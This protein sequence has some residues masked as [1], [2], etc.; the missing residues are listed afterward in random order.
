[1]TSFTLLDKKKKNSASAHTVLTLQ[2]IFVYAFLI[3]LML[4]CL[5]PLWEMLVNSTRSTLQIQ[6]TMGWW[7]GDYLVKN[8]WIGFPNQ[9]VPGLLRNGDL[10]ILQALGNS[11]F[12]AFLTAA[13]TVYFSALTAYGIQVYNFKGKN[14]VF[15]FILLIMMIPT[16]VSAVGFFDLISRMG[17]ID[18]FWPLILPAIASPVSFFFI[19]QYLEAIL[20]MEMVEAARV[21][22]CSEIGIFHRMVLPII[23]PAL[24][25]QF[26]FSF[27]SSWSNLFIPSLILNSKNK[28]TVAILIS[29]QTAS[30][31]YFKQ[32][33]QMYCLISLAIIPAVIV[34]LIFSRFIISNVTEGSVKG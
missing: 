5:F 17:G 6:T 11:T 19:K 27:V 25:I 34:Y 28:W 9:N 22:G 24:A 20:P 30:S 15:T 3:I 8:L 21:D 13:V 33:G 29:Q 10:P 18:H 2:R 31:A 14:A 26:I 1:M 7:F 12:V 16:Q 23:K 4:L 32:Y